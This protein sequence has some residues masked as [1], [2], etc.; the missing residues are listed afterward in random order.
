MKLKSDKR[1]ACDGSGS[2]CVRCVRLYLC[3][4]EDGGGISCGNWKGTAARV[5]SL[6]SGVTR[7]LALG[8]RNYIIYRGALS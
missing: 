7:R 1:V 4:A 2:E 5:N 8:D 3:D 6:M